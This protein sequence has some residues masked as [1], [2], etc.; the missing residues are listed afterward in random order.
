MRLS[1]IYRYAKVKNPDPKD[2][3]LDG[4]LRGLQCSFFF[5]AVCWSDGALQNI[6]FQA[7]NRDPAR[8]V[9]TPKEKSQGFR[10]Q[11]SDRKDKKT[12]TSVFVIW[13][14]YSPSAPKQLPPAPAKPLNAAPRSAGSG[15]GLR[16]RFAILNKHCHVLALE[17]PVR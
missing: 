3:A 17:G 4:P 7:P 9:G 2:P 10:C 5:A 14:F 16:T 12:E 15:T 13:N 8:R 6:K 1:L 11:V